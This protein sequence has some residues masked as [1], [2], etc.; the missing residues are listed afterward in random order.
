MSE[1]YL[2]RKL[3][4]VSSPSSG[5]GIHNWLSATSTL[6]SRKSRASAAMT[7]GGSDVE[8]LEM[9]LEVVDILLVSYAMD[10]QKYAKALDDSYFAG[11]L[12]TSGRHIKQI[13][14][15]T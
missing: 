9:L 14:N 6:G 12:Y 13:D 3:D 2:S 5:N 11:L 10:Y 4:G 7:H 8:E 1:L 15:G